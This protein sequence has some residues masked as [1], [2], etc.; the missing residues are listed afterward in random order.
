M[1][2][3]FAL[4]ALALAACSSDP[5]PAATDAAV[6]LGPLDGGGAVDADPLAA[7]AFDAGGAIPCT[8]GRIEECPCGDGRR[9]AQTCQPSGAYGPCVCSDAGSPMD[10]C[11]AR[12]VSADDACARQIEQVCGPA[13]GSA[14]PA[15]VVRDCGV[16]AGCINIMDGRQIQ[17]RPQHCGACGTECRSGQFCINGSCVDPG[18][19]DAGAS[20]AGRCPSGI[21]AECD[22]RR[23]NLQSGELDG[24]RRYHCGACGNHCAPGEFCVQCTCER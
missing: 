3:L 22:G 23:V 21:S 24:G 19:P 8:A 1:R 13:C 15:C 4:V 7:D 6:D 5:V 17:G 12:D 16:Q 9:G 18:G 10:A 14:R 2:Y 20:D 11:A